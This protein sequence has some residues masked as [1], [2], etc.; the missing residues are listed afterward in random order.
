M[1][2]KNFL[3]GLFIGLVGL[4]LLSKKQ[5]KN[6]V[7]SFNDLPD[8]VLYKGDSIIVRGTNNYYNF[9]VDN[10]V[11]EGDDISDFVKWSMMT[12]NDR[13]FDIDK[14]KKASKELLKFGS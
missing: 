11:Y 6:V 9:K 8:P 2:R 3:K 7:A 4:P 14:L 10:D 5:D 13:P 12:V 1:N